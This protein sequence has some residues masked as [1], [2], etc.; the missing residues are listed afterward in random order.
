MISSAVEAID[1]YED[2]S[3]PEPIAL[4][5]IMKGRGGLR[6]YKQK[7]RHI[8]E[9]LKA[10]VYSSKYP[11]ILEGAEAFA[12]RWGFNLVTNVYQGSAVWGIESPGEV[13][14]RIKRT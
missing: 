11:W 14:T 1:T 5:R 6:G 7:V 12:S 2:P 3:V 9:G 13:E 8:T 10:R 4:W